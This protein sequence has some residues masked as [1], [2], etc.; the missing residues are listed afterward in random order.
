MQLYRFNCNSLCSY[1]ISIDE[2]KEIS[3]DI[4]KVFVEYI[5]NNKRSISKCEGHIKVWEIMGF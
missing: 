4:F 2:L 3:R 5:Q 1:A